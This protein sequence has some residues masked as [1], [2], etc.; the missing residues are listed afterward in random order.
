MRTS[1]SSYIYIVA[2]HLQPSAATSPRRKDA[3]ETMYT[4]PPSDAVA[5]R[6]S[7]G[8]DVHAGYVPW[9]GGLREVPPGTLGYRVV[10]FRPNRADRQTSRPRLGSAVWAVALQ[11]GS[12]A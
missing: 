3:P 10:N 12:V 11:R 4:Y 5:W 6:G 9:P 8:F 7:H 1:I 2:C